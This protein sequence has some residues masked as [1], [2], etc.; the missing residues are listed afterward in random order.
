MCIILYIV[1]DRLLQAAL[2]SRLLS[3]NLESFPGYEHY[4]PWLLQLLSLDQDTQVGML[5]LVLTF[6]SAFRLWDWT[7]SWI[8]HSVIPQMQL[9]ARLPKRDS[10]SLATRQAGSKVAN[11][12]HLTTLLCTWPKLFNSGK[13]CDSLSKDRETQP[14]DLSRQRGD[15]VSSSW[16]ILSGLLLVCI[17]RPNWHL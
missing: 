16:K 9:L 11:L 2:Q 7:L 17:H 10:P 4:P 3:D 14:T 1:D 15:P 13:R 8:L 6:S 12:C 5:K